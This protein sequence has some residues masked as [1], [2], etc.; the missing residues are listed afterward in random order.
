LRA[1]RLLGKAA[2]VYGVRWHDP[3]PFR[4]KGPR[5]S[6]ARSRRVVRRGV[7]PVSVDNLVGAIF[8]S[9]EMNK[10][11]VENPVV[12]AQDQEKRACRRTGRK[13]A[14]GLPIAEALG[15]PLGED[16]FRAAHPPAS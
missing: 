5:E 13:K 7:C 4:E 10:L 16:G 11:A 2:V 15:N 6:N 14:W 12:A 1:L 8:L 9:G 3:G